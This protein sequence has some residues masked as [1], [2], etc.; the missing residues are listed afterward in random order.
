MNLNTEFPLVS[1]G[2]PTFNRPNGLKRTL[3]NI[4]AQR[5]K[6]LEIIVSDNCSTDVD[7]EAV[8]QSFMQN[9]LRISYHR[10]ITNIGSWQ[11]FLFVL[12]KARGDYFM[13]A[14][15]DDEWEPDFVTRCMENM[16]DAGSVMCEFDTVFRAKNDVTKNPIPRLGYSRST[17]SDVSEFFK[18]M[19]PTLIYGLHRRSV[20]QFVFDEKAFDFYDCYFVIKLILENGAR[21]ISGVS[22]RAGVDES[23]YQVKTMNTTS[24]RLNYFPFVFNVLK[25][26]WNSNKLYLSQ[27]IS[28]SILFLNITSKLIAHHKKSSTTK[29]VMTAKNTLKRGL[30]LMKNLYGNIKNKLRKLKANYVLAHYSYSQ[31]GEDLIINFASKAMRIEFP[32]YLDIG[33]HTPVALNNTYLFYKSGSKGVCIEAD[34]DLFKVFKKKRR[35]DIS[36]NCGIGHQDSGQSDF[37]LMT[38]STLN[39]FSKEEAKRCESYGTNFI[40]SVIKVPIFGINSIL[41]KYFAGNSPDIISIDVEGLDFAIISAIDFDRWRPKIFCIETLTY[42]ETRKEEKN[43]AIISFLKSK[44][45]IVYGDTYINTIFV[46]RA[47]WVGGK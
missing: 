46:D 3:E 39:T 41:E 28:L 16:S 8:V 27:K 30:G 10:Q 40:K 23:E 9:D 31:S 7:V 38:N 11:N 6:N 25:I 4:T 26:V 29:F 43:E 37:Y 17:Y 18:C 13:W 12:K 22:Y 19:Q 5:Y 21:T 15:D 20:I 2:I 1:V 47:S 42:S 32:S 45:Y 34:P 35:R 36:L 24:G 33:A 14:A 44:D